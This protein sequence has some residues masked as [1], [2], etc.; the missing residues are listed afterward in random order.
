MRPTGARV[1]GDLKDPSSE[2]YRAVRSAPVQRLKEHTGAEPMIFYRDLPG[3]AN[4]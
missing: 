3:V 4:I 2:V 1:F